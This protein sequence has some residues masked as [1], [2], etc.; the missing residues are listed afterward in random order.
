MKKLVVA[1]A[2][3]LISASAL[4]A[5]DQ[6]PLP[7]YVMLKVNGDEIKRSDVDAV[8]KGVFPGGNAPAFD[9]FDE[10]VQITVLRNIANEHVVLKEAEKTGV[11]NSDEVKAKLA[12]LQRQIVIQAFLKDKI[13]DLTTDDKLK[14]AYDARVKAITA[15]GGQDE[16]H[17]RQIL[18]K[19][20]DD[21]L[22]IEKK[23]KKGSDFDKLAQD[24]TFAQPGAPA[25][26]DLGW[27]T[28]DKL[29]ADMAKTVFAMKK[30]EVSAPIQSDFGWHIIKVEDRRKAAPS[31]FDQMKESLRE[32]IVT[33]YI[34]S[35]TKDVKIIVRDREGHEHELAAAPPA[36]V[37]PAVAPA[38]APTTDKSD[39]KDD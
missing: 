11:Q 20:Q 33:D 22:A 6:A 25:G 28:A 15:N 2:S 21:A 17:A 1:F 27:I 7:D 18:V 14:A 5:D 3:L 23:L 39:K 34:T 36:P 35:L 16:V 8:W 10:K 31:T 32:Q 38:A 9:T 12:A 26:G 37:T 24:K 13:K 4:Y 29:P 19:T 30:G